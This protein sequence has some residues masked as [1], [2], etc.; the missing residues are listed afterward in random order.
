MGTTEKNVSFFTSLGI[1]THLLRPLPSPETS[2]PQSSCSC[3]SLSSLHHL[4]HFVLKSPHY[5][6]ISPG[7]RSI[8]QYFKCSLTEVEKRGKITFLDLLTM[9]PRK[10]TATFDAK[11]HLV[12]SLMSTRMPRAFPA[13]FFSIQCAPVIYWYMGWSNPQVHDCTSFC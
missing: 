2:P 10:I 1:Y 13:E 11:V 4:C 8:E 5:V 9:C 3:L 7:G 6:F 12:V